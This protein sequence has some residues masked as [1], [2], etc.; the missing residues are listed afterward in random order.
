MSIKTG[1]KNVTTSGTPVQIDAIDLQGKQEV[2]VKAKLSNTGIISVGFSS[3]T[4]LKT[5]SSH[6]KLYAG[7]SVRVVVDDLDEV[8]IDS[9]VNGEGIE[10][11]LDIK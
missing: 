3:A 5:S 4:A 8:W 9:T 2:A 7:D 6:F 11:I 10:Y 1:Q